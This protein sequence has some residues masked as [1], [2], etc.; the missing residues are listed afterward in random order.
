MPKKRVIPTTITFP[1]TCGARHNLR[2]GND[3]VHDGCDYAER[4]IPCWN[5][6]HVKITARLWGGY[7]RVSLWI[8]G[9]MVPKNKLEIMQQ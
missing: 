9:V 4:I 7:D 6:A 2:I 3:D 1:C 5:N 8:D